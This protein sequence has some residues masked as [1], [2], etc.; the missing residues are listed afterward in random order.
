[1]I[2][3]RIAIKFF[4]SPDPGAAL[5]LAPAI[6]L[7]HGFIQGKKVEGLL[8]DVADYAH[9]PEGP[10]VVLIG[11]DVDYGIDRA[12]GRT[13]LLVTR[14]HYGD[15][16]LCDALRDTLRKGL[17]A[18]RAIED[19]GSLKLHFA[20]DAFALQFPDRL[21]AP[22]TDDAFAAIQ[23]EIAPVFAELF[24]GAKHEIS[25]SYADDPGKLLTLS[26]AVKETVDADALLARL[27]AAA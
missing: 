4:A 22:N 7:F 9:V 26:V 2:P 10:G 1:M 16:S 13:G 6:D 27:G 11:H 18:I 12:G 20:A 14:K 17:V 5:D 25:W 15:M 3:K 24:G 23:A 19:E 8:I 21:A